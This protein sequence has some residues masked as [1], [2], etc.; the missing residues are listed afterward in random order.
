MDGALQVQNRSGVSTQLRHS[1]GG[2]PS[3]ADR[4]T[5]RLADFDRLPLLFWLYDS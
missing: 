1:V 4:D 2:P 5:P 3:G